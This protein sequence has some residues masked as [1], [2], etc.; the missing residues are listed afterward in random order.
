MEWKIAL[1]GNRRRYVDV[2]R[3]LRPQPVTHRVE[4]LP[5]SEPSDPGGVV[6]SDV[7][8]T[9][10]EWTDLELLD[11]RNPNAIEPSKR[12]RIR[13]TAMAVAARVT[14]NEEPAAR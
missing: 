8:G 12:R 10:G 3:L 1:S 9:R 4:E 14:D 7:L 11:L 2:R 13:P 6:R 5:L